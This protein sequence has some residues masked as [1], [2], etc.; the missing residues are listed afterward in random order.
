MNPADFQI[1]QLFDHLLPMDVG[2]NT[3]AKTGQAF[4][5]TL[6]SM[7]RM[8]EAQPSGSKETLDGQGLTGLEGKALIV[9]LKKLLRQ[10]GL[11]LDAVTVDDP[12]LAAFKR[13]MV[14]SGFDTKQMDAL[15][16]ELTADAGKNGVRLSDLFKR[17]SDLEEKKAS[18]EILAPGAYPF[19]TSILSQLLPDAQKQRLAW[20]GVQ[21]TEAGIDMARL[22]SNLKDILKNL[23][24]KGRTVPETSVQKQVAK[25]MKDM[26]L[27]SESGTVTLEKFVARLEAAASASNR[28]SAVEKASTGADL[29]Q[30]M[31]N[32]RP[33]KNPGKEIRDPNGTDL[34]KAAVRDGGKRVSSLQGHNAHAADSA[35][36]EIKNPASGNRPDSIKAPIGELKPAETVFSDTPKTLDPLAPTASADAKLPVRTLPA[37]VVH[38]VSRQIIRSVQNRTHE[39][40]LQLN[41][42]NLGRLQ[43]TIDSSGEMLR[44]HIITEQQ[45]TRE[46]L[47]S[48][49]GDLKTILTDQGLRLEKIDVQFDQHYDQSLSYA[50]QE[51]NRFTGRRHGG[52]SAQNRTGTGS[53]EESGGEA[54]PS[55]EG[56]LDLVA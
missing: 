6:Q 14:A 22:I 29:K 54:P 52:A 23:P 51:S 10:D 13:L 37:Y 49:A 5:G 32:L 56:L 35:E 25:L 2:S 9:R 3:I 26:G 18:E 4:S 17:I 15:I 41:P 43:L 44:V 20:Q 28:P 36:T 11:D 47:M 39:I 16:A 42:P 34:A 8:S 55:T 19:I 24:D 31:E 27:A 7:L 38:Q 21:S 1:N 46:L 33:V 53:P 40:R 12:A 50:R 30:F 48:H 45:S